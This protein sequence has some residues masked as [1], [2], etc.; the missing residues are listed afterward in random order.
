MFYMYDGSRQTNESGLLRG[1]KGKKIK[2]N[3]RFRRVELMR[4]CEKKR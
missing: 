4:E 1:E 2:E 3:G